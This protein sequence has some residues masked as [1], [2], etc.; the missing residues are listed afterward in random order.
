MWCHMGNIKQTLW[1]PLMHSNMFTQRDTNAHAQARIHGIS[2]C[3]REFDVWGN[4]RPGEV[5]LWVL[6]TRLRH[7]AHDPCVITLA[8]NRAPSNAG[9][10]CRA[11]RVQDEVGTSGFKSPLDWLGD[12]PTLA[13]VHKKDYATWNKTRAKAERGLLDR[14]SGI[15]GQLW[16]W[17]L[18]LKASNP[19]LLVTSIPLIILFQV[20]WQLIDF[21]PFFALNK[22]NP[23]KYSDASVSA[24]SPTHSPA[25]SLTHPHMPR[26]R[27]GWIYPTNLFSFLPMCLSGWDSAVLILLFIFPCTSSE[28]SH[29][30]ICNL[31]NTRIH[32]KLPFCQACTE[33]PPYNRSIP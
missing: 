5:D 13:F 12:V 22:W 31:S 33:F 7:R 20:H 26:V 28:R 18:S 14:H 6:S 32:S 4:H 30:Y 8:S 21:S 15:S 2:V 1:F 9:G 27:V 25:H 29:T 16:T 24:A 23:N 17:S 19:Y 11:L 10:P 3:A